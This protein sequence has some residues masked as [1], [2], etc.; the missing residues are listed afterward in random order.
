M[1]IFDERIHIIIRSLFIGILNPYSSSND[2]V[3]SSNPIGSQP[4]PQT[5]HPNN[6][7]ASTF[8][9]TIMN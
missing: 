3:P 5:Q 6:S 9:V 1:L 7:N 2:T 4:N 8:Y